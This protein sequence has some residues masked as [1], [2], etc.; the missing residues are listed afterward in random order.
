MLFAL[1][2]A[3][4]KAVVAGAL[5]ALP[6]PTAVMVRGLRPAENK[7]DTEG[8]EDEEERRDPE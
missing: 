3:L 5:G 1:G 4:L 2:P 7:L 6:L 8:L